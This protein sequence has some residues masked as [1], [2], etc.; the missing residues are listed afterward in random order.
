MVSNIENPF[1]EEGN[2]TTTKD[3]EEQL[4]EQLK[5]AINLDLTSTRPRF[6]RTA[7][8]T[9]RYPEG[10]QQTCLVRHPLGLDHHPDLNEPEKLTL[11]VLGNTFSG[12]Q[13]QLPSMGG[14]PELLLPKLSMQDIGAKQVQ[15]PG[16]RT[17]QMELPVVYGREGRIYGFALTIPALHVRANAT[18]QAH[19]TN[20][21]YNYQTAYNNMA[22]DAC[23]LLK[24]IIK[25]SILRYRHQPGLMAHAIACSELQPDE[26]G[27]SYAMAARKC[28]TDSNW[29]DF[30]DPWQLDGHPAWGLRYPKASSDCPIPGYLRVIKG[31]GDYVAFNPRTLKDR[32]LGDQ[33]G[34]LG[35]VALNRDDFV[36]P[37]NR[38]RVELNRAITRMESKLCLSD[39]LDPVGRLGVSDKQAARWN[40]NF[41]GEDA[42][43]AAS[44]DMDRKDDVAVFTMIWGWF[45]SQVLITRGAKKDPEKWGVIRGVTDSYDM[46][47]KRF[48]EG[49]MDARKDGSELAAPIDIHAFLESCMQGGVLPSTKQLKDAKFEEPEINLM[50]TCWN[51]S[52]GNIRQAARDSAVYDTFVVSRSKVDELLPQLLDRL[53]QIGYRPD[54]I[55]GAILTELSGHTTTRWS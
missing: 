37:V 11:T 13:M 47:L 21:P 3:P 30:Q 35:G 23:Q 49:S 45:A 50:K 51:L 24:Y 18:L 19:L 15:V 5:A 54:Q 42:T 10:Q 46:L 55:L 40:P 25:R 44:H 12:E 48:M 53:I 26:F 4:I 38:P 31:R 34:D 41:I 1:L 7:T 39:V 52:Q 16:T 22:L 28:R 2:L 33:D 9:Y 29:P 6:I 8:Q 43:L 27:I 14:F 20:R 36:L 17:R 32:L